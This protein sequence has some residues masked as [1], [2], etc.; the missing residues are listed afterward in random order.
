M[1]GILGKKLGMTQVFTPEGIGSSG[2]C[3]SSRSMC[4]TSKERCGER[5]L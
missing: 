3:Y 5:W 4:R 2:N 1:K